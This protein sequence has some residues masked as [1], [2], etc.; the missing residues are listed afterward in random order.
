MAMYKCPVCR[1]PIYAK[2]NSKAEELY[3]NHLKTHG[4]SAAVVTSERTGRPKTTF[5]EA[6]TDGLVM[7]HNCKPCP[8]C[9]NKRFIAG[10]PCIHCHGEGVVPIIE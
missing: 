8:I 9:R 10:I 6:R 2:S 1:K 5:H 3:T 4:P 7:G